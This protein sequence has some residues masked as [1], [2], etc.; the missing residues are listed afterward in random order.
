MNPA[1]ESAIATRARAQLGLVTLA[2]LR[3][4]GVAHSTIGRRTASGTWQQVG[5]RTILVAPA[6]ID[7]RTRVLAGC[8]DLRGTS[9]HRASTWLHG[10]IEQ[11]EALDVTVVKGRSVAAGATIEGLVVHTTTSLPAEDVTAIGPIPAM[12]VARSLFGL[13]AL[14]PDVPI[15]VLEGAVEEAVRR[16]LAS[17]RWLWWLLEQRRRRGRNGVQRFEAVLAARSD[18]GPTESWLERALL[19]LI[20]DAGLPRPEVQRRITQRGA[21]VARVDL[22]YGGGAIV[23]EALGYR[24]HA[25][26]EQQS[27]DAARASRLQLAGCE[28]HQFT[29]DQI[30]RTPELVAE[31]IALALTRAGLLRAA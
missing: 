13:A 27:R 8:L 18:L 2:Q 20:D 19:Q 28:V 1:K 17:D 9:S 22:A 7:A 3:A 31:I 16:N 11:P 10:L 4:L 6:P 12:S 15:E 26:R 30:V 25:T 23:I 24:Y 5:P 21:F 29:Y 14:D